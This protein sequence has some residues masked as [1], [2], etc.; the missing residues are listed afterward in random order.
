MHDFAGGS[1]DGSQPEYGV[2]V[3]VAGY[4]YGMTAYG[5]VNNNGVVFKQQ[6]PEPTVLVLVPIA[7]GLLLN[8]GCCLS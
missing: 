1:S 3:E 2:L 6:V 4:Y 5:G 7:A 8:V